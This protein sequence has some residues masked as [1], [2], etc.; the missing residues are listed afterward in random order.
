MSPLVYWFAAP[1]LWLLIVG[2]FAWRSFA[3]E[4]PEIG[5]DWFYDQAVTREAD[6]V[7]DLVINRAAPS[8]IER[9]LSGIAAVSGLV[10]R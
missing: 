5:T 2:V 3:N 7:R 8:L 10:D 9:E 6:R 1:F 4:Q